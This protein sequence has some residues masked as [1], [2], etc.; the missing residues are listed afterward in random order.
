MILGDFNLEPTDP[1]ISN[2]LEINDMTNIIKS[3]TCFK[4][5][6]G[7]CIDLIL[8]NTPKNIKNKGT[9][10]TGLSDFHR[11][12]FSMLKTKYTKLRPRIF[13]YRDYRNF[14]EENFL[15]EL[16][17]CLA[18]N[19]IENYNEFENILINIVNRHVPLKTKYLRANNKPYISKELRKAIMKRSHLKNLAIKSDK[20]EDEVNYRRQRNLVVKLNRKAKRTY[21]SSTTRKTKHF[22]DAVKPQF[23][24][25]SCAAEGR[26]QL[27]ENETLHTSDVEVADV[28][29]LYF[30]RI[31]DNL[32]IPKWECQESPLNSDN[33]LKSIFENHPSIKEIKSK[34]NS[35]EV[36]DFAQVGE[37]EVFK[38]IFIKF[39]Q[40][41][42]CKWEYTDSCAE[43][44]CSFL[45]TISNL[46]F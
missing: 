2:F 29:N 7:S 12:I 25:K 19:L 22:W 35:E 8:T 43:N 11:L 38:A 37:R 18:N 1:K 39:E 40:L 44:C 28:F 24:D 14:H 10:E 32:E 46:L 27:L 16:E 5:K 33:S 21:F 34:K 13:K 20:P 30:N 41:K 45:H 17:Y 3:K 23:S 42:I 6:S 9:V 26:V 36:F 4:S 15:F 31:T